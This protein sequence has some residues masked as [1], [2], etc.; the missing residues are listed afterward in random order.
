[1]PEARDS[2]VIDLDEADPQTGPTTVAALILGFLVIASSFGLE[3]LYRKTADA[4][5][6]RK[7]ISQEPAELRTVQSG[8]IDQLRDY[9]WVDES[10][11]VVAVPIDR[12]MELVISES[13]AEHR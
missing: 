11:G 7:V 2:H 5:R 10:H 12:A 4:E 1:M 8:Q 13:R 6:V 3:A 9:R